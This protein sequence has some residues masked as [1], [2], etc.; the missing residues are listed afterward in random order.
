MPGWEL[1]G[2][3]EKEA[4]DEIFDK[5]NGVLYRY[6]L[7]QRRNNIFRAKEF[8]SNLAQKLGVKHC[9][10]VCNG[11]AALK[12]ALIA[13]GVKAGDEVITQSFTFV[14]TAEAVLELGAKLVIT[15]VDKS[16]NMDPQDLKR[17]I[18]G[19]TKVII[20]V[21]MSGVAAEMDEIMAIAKQKNIYVLE[22]SCQALGG[23]YKGKYLGTIGNAGAYSLDIGKIITAGEGGVLVTNDDNIYLKA[24]EYSDHGHQDKVGVPRGEDTHA[25][26]GFNY[27]V[28]ELQGAVALAQLKKLDYILETQKKNK[29]IIKDALRN[30]NGIEFR[31]LPD[32][33]GDAGDTLIFFVENKEKALGFAKKLKE[34]GL[35]TKNLPDALNW[36]F[37]C[38]WQHIFYNFDEYKNKDLNQIWGQSS[39]LVQRSIAIPILIK[40][41]EIQIRK[42][43]SAIQEIFA[44]IAGS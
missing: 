19:K 28:T 33:E 9:L 5:S 17:K 39:G 2:K 34:R 13:M 7:D 1:I 22:D 26:W 6:G 21:H 16:L 38:N 25:D 35:G 27:K 10:F 29:K 44:D 24:K 11:T 12:I 23:K 18:T 14:A 8:E 42:T 37:A 30:I 43:I 36:H 20:P 4:L 40:M 3:E 41:D 31:Q 32:E 15:E